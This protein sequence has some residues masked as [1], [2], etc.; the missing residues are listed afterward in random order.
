MPAVRPQPRVENASL[1]V[2]GDEMSKRPSSPSFNCFS[3][4]SPK[5]LPGF[6]HSSLQSFKRRVSRPTARCLPNC[7]MIL[8]LLRVILFDLS[9]FSDNIFRFSVDWNIGFGDYGSVCSEVMGLLFLFLFSVWLSRKH[10]EIMGPA[11]ILCVFIYF[12]CHF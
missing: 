2:T 4:R 11:L 1:S 8:L 9:R 5:I 3:N 6:F 7:C 12:G 10:G